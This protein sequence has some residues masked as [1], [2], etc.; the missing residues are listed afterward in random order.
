MPSPVAHSLIG[1]S[2]FLL[3]TRKV[4]PVSLHHLMPWRNR[5]LVFIILANLPD[6]DFLI[7]WLTTGNANLL[8]NGWTH[9]LLF[10]IIVAP[11]IATISR[12]EATY[13]KSNLLI[14]GVVATHVVMDFFTGPVLG[15]SKSYGIPILAPISTERLQS[16][17]SLFVGP[18]HQTLD[19]IF[20][21]HNWGWVSFEALVLAPVVLLIIMK[22]RAK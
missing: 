10:A 17:V 18:K 9:T 19:Q 8:H 11:I 12:L 5:I 3:T 16:P 4:K 6:I 22:R 2:L 21:L 13:L 15:F 14:S 20:S 7:S 1:F